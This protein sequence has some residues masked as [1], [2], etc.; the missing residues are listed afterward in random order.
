MLHT[1]T[2]RF[3]ADTWATILAESHRLGIAHAAFI[4]CAVLHYI[5]CTVAAERIGVL[6][7]RV[8]ALARIVGVRQRRVT[9]AR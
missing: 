6:E 4:R 7:R 2:V 1:T 9:G 5:G 3:H 8:E